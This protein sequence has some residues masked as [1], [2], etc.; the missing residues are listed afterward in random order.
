MQSRAHPQH[1]ARCAVPLIELQRQVRRV[2][3]WQHLYTLDRRVSEPQHRFAKTLWRLGSMSAS[4]VRE[5]D[6]REAVT[7]SMAV[8]YVFHI[9]PRLRPIKGRLAMKQRRPRRV[10]DLSA[11]NTA[12]LVPYRVLPRKLEEGTASPVRSV[13]DE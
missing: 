13:G 12:W 1:V 5:Q 11:Q 8:R 4:L 2:P 6:Y 3:V 7:E 10:K 9:G